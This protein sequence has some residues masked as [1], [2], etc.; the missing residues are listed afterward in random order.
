MNHNNSFNNSNV[1]N[2]DSINNGNHYYNTD[3]KKSSIKKGEDIFYSLNISKNSQEIRKKYYENSEMKSKT[4]N[5]NENE[6]NN[7]DSF[8]LIQKKYTF[9]SQKS[10]QEINPSNNIFHKEENNLNPMIKNINNIYQRSYKTRIDYPTELITNYRFWKGNNYFCLKGK[11]IMGPSGFKPTLMTG[12]ATTIPILL[13]F[14]FEAEYMTDELT[15]FIPLLIGILYILILITLI[16]A[17]FI[18]PGIIRRFDIKNIAI[19]E[20]YNM[21]KQRIASRIFHLGHIMTYKYCYTC[22]II[23]PN[24]STHCAECNNCVERLDHHCPWIG[25]CAGKRN[26]IYFFIFLTLINILQILLII[27]CLIHIIKLVK[28]YSDM[29]EKLSLSNKIPHIT[30]YAFCDVVMAV[31]LIIYA[32]A[33]MFFTTPLIIY[34]I[35]LILTD[36]TTKEKLRN[37]FYNGNPFS[38]NN[39]QNVKNVLFP[40]IK[41]YSILHILRGD[42]KEICDINNER[43]YKNDSKFLLNDENSNNIEQNETAIHLKLNT[44]ISDLNDIN[45]NK[46]NEPKLGLNISEEK[47]TP[48]INEE[49]NFDFKNDNI[50][51]KSKI[52]FITPIKYLEPQ[53]T[54][55]EQS[56]NSKKDRKMDYPEDTKPEYK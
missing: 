53:D 6:S 15:V 46:N 10:N 48:D 27:F 56:F 50:Q 14:I 25:H 3:T 45:Y 9:K 33:F 51:E 34:H 38:R 20:R 41:K 55:T 35:K 49:N 11:I 1:N 5:N 23:R 26:Y 21:D 42:Y 40:E 28:D 17:S 30:S 24:R 22:G 54:I 18:D 32:I 31:F 19:K 43:N 16:I 44:L 29:N 39:W 52:N 47:I 37:A 4:I 8:K 2:R 12:T 36:T 7:G 13:F